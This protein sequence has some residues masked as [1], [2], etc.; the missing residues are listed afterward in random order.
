MMKQVMI[1]GSTG[2]IGQSALDVIRRARAKFEVL[3]I[4]ANSNVA[5]LE[6]QIREFRPKYICVAGEENAKLLKGKIGR[7]PQFFTGQEGLRDFS[8]I[9][10]DIAIMAIAGISCLEP[11]LINMRRA[12]RVALA[13]K[14]SVVTAGNFV[15]NQAKKFG[16]EIIPVDSEINA[17]FQLLE[18][19]GSFKR[20]YL[21]AS[22]GSLMGCRK[23]DLAK[24]SVKTVLSHPTWKM[25]KR[26]TVDSATLVNKGFEVIEAHYFFNLS[27]EDI[28][29]IVHRE[30]MIHALAECGDNSI[31]ACLYPADMRMPLAFAL[32]HPQ[33]YSLY[34]S[35]DFR[36]K[37]SLSFEPLA[38][39]LF[40]LFELLL[41][42]G[43]RKDNSAVILNACDE[44]A[45]EYFLKEKIKF[46][47]IHKAMHYLFEHYPCSKLN[48][49]G[50][51]FFWD[52][53]AREKTRSY[54]EELC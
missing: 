20:V 53:W 18:R 27:Y 3:G 52:S 11:L 28:A 41:E 22:G 51:V 24:V 2:S 46:T 16:T 33:K 1:F 35:I 13:N 45:V 23:K 30:S 50:D 15:F 17:L 44:V 9:S 43:K 38:K 8:G 42:A 7:K 12:K 32:H 47:D 4:C 34:E 14:E 21:T 6:K 40:P 29:V 54:L 25:G 10:C 39:G 31:F 49:I 19:K 48:S 37:F 5:V 26:I 36:K